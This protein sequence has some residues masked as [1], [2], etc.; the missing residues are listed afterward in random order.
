MR[1]RYKQR[2]PLNGRALIV[3]D[4]VLSEGRV[5]DITAPGCLI[6]SSRVVTKGQYLDLTM[7]LPGIK[8]PLVIKLGAVRWTKGKRFGVEF[9]IMEE[10]ERRILNTLIAENLLFTKASPRSP[11]ASDTKANQSGSHRPTKCC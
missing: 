7:F 2:I 1:A 8:S 11:A 3:I 10:S 9:I 4:S 5:L 6:E